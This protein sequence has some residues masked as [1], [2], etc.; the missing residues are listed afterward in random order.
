[1][2][3]VL[4]THLPGYVADFEKLKAVGAEVI[5]CVSV[6][7]AFVMDAWGKDHKAD[8]KVRQHSSR[9]CLHLR[10]ASHPPPCCGVLAR[11]ANRLQLGSE[12]IAKSCPACCLPFPAPPSH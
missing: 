6:N 4:Q 11:H 2:C 8:G 3:A 5:A 9:P 1:M 12:G 7:D 10:C